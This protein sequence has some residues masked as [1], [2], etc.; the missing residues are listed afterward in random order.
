[1]PSED[2]T[3]DIGLPC[4]ILTDLTFA[5]RLVVRPYGLTHATELLRLSD[6]TDWRTQPNCSICPTLRN[7][8]RNRTDPVFR[9]YW[10]TYATELLLL[11][12]TL[13][14][15]TGL[16]VPTTPSRLLAVRIFPLLSCNYFY[17]H[18]IQ[19]RSGRN[20]YEKWARAMH[21]RKN[22]IITLSRFLSFFSAMQS[23][24]RK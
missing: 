13:R 17:I 10:L 20:V 18:K 24:P 2:E 11:C 9:P 19:I 4:Y 8:V 7:D 5:D 15:N 12:P 21:Q 22:D 3:K 6:P 1:M 14:I 16:V 23:F